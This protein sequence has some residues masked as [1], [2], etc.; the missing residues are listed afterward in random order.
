MLSAPFPPDEK[1]RLELLHALELLDSPPE[2]SFDR[3]TRLVSRALGVPI[4][5]VSLVDAER[6]WFKSRIGIEAT[7]TPRD[8]A[9]CAHAITLTKPLVVADAL[10]DER[11]CDNPLVLEAPRIRF[12]AGVPIV[13]K[14]GLALGTLCAVDQQPRELSAAELEILSDL[15]E[16]LSQEVQQREMLLHARNQLQKSGSLLLNHEARYRAMFEL[17]SVGI[18]MVAPD[19]SWLSINNALCE[20]VGYT[21]DELTQV[22]FRAI[23]H[24]DDLD[25]DLAQLQRLARGEVES[26]QLEKRYLRKGGEPVWVALSVTRKASEEGGVEYYI[27]IIKD[28]QARKEAEDALLALTCNLELKVLERTAELQDSNQKLNQAIELQLLAT[29]A[30]RKREAQLS[31]IIE[32]ATEAFISIDQQGRVTAWNPQAETIFGWSAG[33]ALGAPLEQLVMPPDA[34][35]GYRQALQGYLQ[36][37]EGEYLNQRR[38][39]TA[40]R[41]DGTPITV[42]VC[43]YALDID[44]ERSFSAFLHDITERKRL[45]AQREQEASRDALTGLLN[46]R[47]MNELLPLAQARADRSGQQ[48]GVLFIDLDGFK[49]I[50]DT[51]GHDA[52]DRLLQVIGGRLSAGVRCTD[53]VIR[54]AGDEFIVILEGLH[55][56]AEEART[57]AE[58]LL[59]DIRQ[60]VP[61][62]GESA[63]VG[64]SIG[65]S[66]YCPRSEQDL[67][68]LVQEADSLMYRAKQNGKGHVAAVADAS[69]E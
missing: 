27:A 33:E 19:G 6:Q 21:S 59:A 36:Y 34:V 20:I 50:N 45:E 52:G 25:A 8:I 43:V 3:I 44:G 66:I 16:I 49:A 31:T 64:A 35:C 40:R 68:A 15:A 39:M 23:T 46:R 57:I 32:V 38:E 17:A 2:A 55:E 28:I 24:P 41:R 69:V 58:K 54:P 10:Q 26:Y 56:G 1:E 48:L 5:L 53:S 29:H 37:G 62:H 4:A 30:L 22:T 7:E 11:F 47:A 63:R 51:F 65:M 60:P 42:E 13:S 14:G 12:Y 61:L 9:F 67:A 18:A